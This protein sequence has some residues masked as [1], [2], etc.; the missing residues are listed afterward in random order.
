ML[1]YLKHLITAKIIWDNKE[2]IACGCYLMGN[3]IYD[4]SGKII[5]YTLKNIRKCKCGVCE[6]R[7]KKGL[8]P[9]HD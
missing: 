6:E 2:A 4:A 3:V 8:K 1:E 7:I 9:V 5:G